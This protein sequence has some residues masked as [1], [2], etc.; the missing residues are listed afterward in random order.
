MEWEIRIVYLLDF[1]TKHVIFI[2]YCG[3]LILLI[4]RISYDAAIQTY[5]SCMYELQIKIFL[6]I[7]VFIETTKIIYNEGVIC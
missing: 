7:L 2:S 1:P 5:C 6:S 3:G 4:K